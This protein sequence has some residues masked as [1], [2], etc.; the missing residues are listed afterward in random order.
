MEQNKSGTMTKLK[1]FLNDGSLLLVIVILCMY[2]SVK[3]P[4]FSALKI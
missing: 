1:G 2:F 4:Y 3:S